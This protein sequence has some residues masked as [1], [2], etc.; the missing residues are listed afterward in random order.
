MRGA[1]PFLHRVAYDGYGVSS[2][3]MRLRG[4]LL[5]DML[6]DRGLQLLNIEGF[7]VSRS[8]AYSST[9]RVCAIVEPR[10][11]VC[12]RQHIPLIT[13]PIHKASIS[14]S[15]IATQTRI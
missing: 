11:T 9:R 2:T 10:K 3:Q 1:L 12:L 6:R 5:K 15:S 13:L 8:C 7:G 4:A 14:I